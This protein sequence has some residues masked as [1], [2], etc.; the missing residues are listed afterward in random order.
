MTDK[1]FPGNPTQS[2]RSREPFASLASLSTGSVIRPRSSRPCEPHSMPCSGTKGADRGL[3][4]PVVDCQ[5]SGDI[6]DR[7]RSWQSRLRAGARPLERVCA[8][9]ECGKSFAPSRR[10]ARTCSLVCRSRFARGSSVG[11]GSCA[12]DGAGVSERGDA[13]SLLLRQPRRRAASV[14]VA[15]PPR[16]CIRRGPCVCGRLRVRDGRPGSICDASVSP[17]GSCGQRRR[18]GWMRRYP[19]VKKRSGLSLALDEPVPRTRPTCSSSSTARSSATAFVVRLAVRDLF[20][21][22]RYFGASI[23]ARDL[24]REFVQAWTRRAE[25]ASQ[26]DRFSLGGEL[27]PGVGVGAHLDK[28]RAGSDQCHGV[29]CGPDRAPVR[30][31]VA[32][33]PGHPRED[34]GSDAASPPKRLSE[35]VGRVEGKRFPDAGRSFWLSCAGIRIGLRH[36]MGILADPR[37]VI[38]LVCVSADERDPART[39][40]PEQPHCSQC[41]IAASPPRRR[42]P[43]RR[44]E[45]NSSRGTGSS[46]RFGRGRVSGMRERGASASASFTDS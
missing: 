35:A 29:R 21:R 28:G 4:R 8:N 9:P 15:L 44:T 5:A 46:G 17:T 19:L 16:R 1:K 11:A 7:W 23:D 32:A 2:F 3:G 40:S 27:L 30:G 12:A 34:F 20:G 26:G 38:V 36:R 25:D 18:R 22:D 13:L 42:P 31:L 24:R 10:D 41:N 33:L 14:P 6:R 43:A 39:G 37:R 45:S